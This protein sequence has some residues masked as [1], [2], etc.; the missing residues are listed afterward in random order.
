VSDRITLMKANMYEQEGKYEKALLELEKVID[1]FPE[2]IEFNVVAAELALKSKNK[3]LAADYYKAV[4]E[5]D[6]MNIFAIT[7]LTDYFREK[8]KIS[9]SFYFLNKS[10]ESDEIPFDK[11][12]AILSYYLT[13][14]SFYKSNTSLL[15]PLIQT[16]QKKYS[17]NYELSLIVTDYYVQNRK[18]N[19]AL[20]AILPLLNERENKYSLW[21]QGI[22]LANATSRIENMYEISSK[23]YL[24]YPDSMEVIF[25][26]GAAEFELGKLESVLQTFTINNLTKINNT[27]IY[28]QSR[29]ML[30]EANH[31][32][33]YHDVADSLFRR[34]ILEEP[35]NYLVMNN[36]S[37]YLSLRDTCLEEARLLSLKTIETYPENGTFLDTYAWILYKLKRYEEAEN[38]IRKA[39][40]FGGENDPDINEH[41]AEINLE[42]GSKDLA[43]SFL[44][45]AILLGGDKEQLLEKLNEIQK[46]NAL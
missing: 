21:R 23:A 36:F 3:D 18:Y 12:I 5:L 42:L 6:S 9:D 32:L 16:L 33:K 29:I 40:K 4:F 46:M 20:N 38:Y 35:K 41:A 22:L 34:I 43:I 19:E 31:R 45:K 39:L 10:F 7:N 15:E 14:D 37:Y 1:L 8:D 13:N 25:F 2:S 26:K 28:S 44:Q 11:K 30:A 17:N 24:K 27:E